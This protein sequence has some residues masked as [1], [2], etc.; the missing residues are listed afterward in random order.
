MGHV[1]VGHHWDRVA[2]DLLDLIGYVSQVKSICVSDGR[3]FLQMDGGLSIAGQD[4][5]VCGGR[6]LPV[7]CAS[8]RYA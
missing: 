8:L 3:L 5:L 2:M 7:R 4:R 6:F 1:A